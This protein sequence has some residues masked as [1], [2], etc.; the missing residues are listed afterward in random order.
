MPAWLLPTAVYVLA[1]GA[2][3]VVG[4]TALNSMAWQRLVVWMGI[5]YAVLA[6]VLLLAGDLALTL[7]ADTPWAIASAALVIAGLVLLYLALGTGDASKVVPV[8]AAY[9]AVT[10]LLSVVALSESLTVASLGGMLL[11]V[12]GVS[13]LTAAK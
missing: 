4:K 3:G 8:S 6:V 13:I 10:L 1:I 5:G 11:V 7:N 2:L 9:P 12:A